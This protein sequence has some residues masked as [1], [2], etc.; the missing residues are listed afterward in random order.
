MGDTREIKLVIPQGFE[1]DV[2]ASDL[3]NGVVAMKEVVIRP[4]QC[5]EELDNIS[6]YYSDNYSIIKKIEDYPADRNN[7]NVYP[8]REDA[9][10]ARALSQLLQLHYAIVGDA[11]CK[12]SWY[13]ICRDGRIIQS[14]WFRSGT[15]L[16]LSFPTKEVAV[17]FADT[18]KELLLVATQFKPQ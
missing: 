6:G 7:R 4:A 17:D 9:E 18:H 15:H 16:E 8:K 12:E 5:F 10:A 13:A 14:R 1:V 2:E 11:E 3:V